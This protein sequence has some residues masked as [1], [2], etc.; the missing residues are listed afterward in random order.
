MDK[1]PLPT[2]LVAPYRQSEYLRRRVL[3]LGPSATSK[4]SHTASHPAQG[5]EDL[6]ESMARALVEPL[7]LSPSTRWAEKATENGKGSSASVLKQE[8]KRR[9]LRTKLHHYQLDGVLWMLQKETTIDAGQVS[10]GILA[11]ESCLGKIAQVLGL[12]VSSRHLQR[13]GPTLVVCST[14]KI[15]HWMRQVDVHMQSGRELSLISWEGPRRCKDASLLCVQ[16]MIITDYPT[17]RADL[18]MHRR[19]RSLLSGIKWERSVLCV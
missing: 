17:F 3:D 19:G 9:G 13:R 18:R 6:R 4:A 1:Q 14:E 15:R 12:V 10:G 7:A 5:E 8:L 16:D 11:D 2:A